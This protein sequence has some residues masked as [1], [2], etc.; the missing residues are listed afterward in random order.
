MID[1]HPFTSD[2]GNRI[3]DVRVTAIA[4]AMDLDATIRAIPGVIG[5]GLFIGMADAV[6]VDHGQTVDVH[7][8]GRPRAPSS[9]A[10]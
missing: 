4:G 8:R 1:G 6:L 3:L 7:R 9:E 10:K 5:T 2:N